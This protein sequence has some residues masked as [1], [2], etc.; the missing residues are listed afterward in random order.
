ML[1]FNK[2]VHV[3]NFWV[4]TKLIYFSRLK[5]S[6]LTYWRL[7]WIKSFEKT[8]HLQ[9]TSLY[10][11]I[12]KSKSEKLDGKTGTKSSGILRWQTHQADKESANKSISFTVLSAQ[13]E[14]FAFRQISILLFQVEHGAPGSTAEGGNTVILCPLVTWSSQGGCQGEI[15]A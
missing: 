3:R 6:L 9:R 12:I 8:Y 10:S 14:N 5:M 1:S 15:P 11:E 4:Q 2:N 7:K 13:R